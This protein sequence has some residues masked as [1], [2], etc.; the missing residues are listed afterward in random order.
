[1]LKYSNFE[2][3]SNLK[4]I[5][6]NIIIDKL[7]LIIINNNC[8]IYVLIKIYKI[9]FKQL[10]HKKIID[11]FFIKIKFDL[12]LQIQIYNKNK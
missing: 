9:F 12:I 11:G 6:T 8:E 3:I 2:I 1:M 4:N 5:I 10:N 7:N